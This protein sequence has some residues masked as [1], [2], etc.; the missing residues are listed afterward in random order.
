VSAKDCDYTHDLRV[1]YSECD[2]F[3][4]RKAFFYWAKTC[5]P[6][7]GL[8]LPEPFFDID[9]R[10]TC[11]DGEEIKVDPVKRKLYCAP[12]GV[13]SYSVGGGGILIDGRMGDWASR[14]DIGSSVPLRMDMSC[15]VHD[16]T[17]SKEY[18]KNYYCEPWSVT[19]NS[20]KAYRGHI[21]DTIVEFDV[22]Y[23]VYFE[24]EG[25]V[26]FKYRKDGVN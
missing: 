3:D 17:Y 5:T 4:K 14:G 18:E 20:I 12:C 2:T 9:C 24:T 15:K 13:N 16:L 10:D 23:A 22:T 21:T 25:Y 26:E 1:D 6:H 11:K 19:G 8:P 7:E